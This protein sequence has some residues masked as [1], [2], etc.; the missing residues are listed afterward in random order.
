MNSYQLDSSLSN[1]NPKPTTYGIEQGAYQSNVKA[2]TQRE[3]LS[4]PSIYQAKDS[5]AASDSY[6]VRHSVPDNAIVAVPSIAAL[7]SNMEKPPT[8][9]PDVA[10]SRSAAGRGNSAPLSRERGSSPDHRGG[11]HSD[12]PSMSKYGPTGA[13]ASS[14][15]TRTSSRHTS[16]KDD[17]RDDA[18]SRPS[19]SSR[20]RSRSRLYYYMLTLFPFYWT[21]GPSTLIFT[22]SCSKHI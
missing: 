11:R 6:A 9:R 18:R 1:S 5:Y 13:L 17:R 20:T 2:Q 19:N 3:S 4:K 12:E 7:T 15:T 14:S 22:H 16:G 10:A 21:S 8:R